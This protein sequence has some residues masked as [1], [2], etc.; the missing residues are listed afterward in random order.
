MY[1]DKMHSRV[2]DANRLGL[3]AD[4]KPSKEVRTVD[5]LPYLPAL[6]LTKDLEHEMKLTL[7]RVYRRVVDPEIL[8]WQRSTTGLG[9]DRL[10]HL[11]GV[12]GHPVHT[13][14]HHHD[15]GPDGKRVLVDDGAF[16]RMVSQLWSYCGMGDPARKRRKGMSQDEAT[17]LGNPRAKSIVHEMAK[18]CM[19]QNGGLNKNGK[20]KPLS[21]YRA[22][23]DD[24]RLA[25]R[26]RVEENGKP[27]SDEHSHNDALHIVAKAIL[28]DLWIVANGMVE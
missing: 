5:P 7:A 3:T 8:A 14:G 24:R 10:A 21:P 19:I 17:A 9:E 15:D 13:I 2:A 4:G 25:T 23:Y 26:G 16:D 20:A 22:V 12:I 28:R 11:L 18:D 6:E 27:W 1:E